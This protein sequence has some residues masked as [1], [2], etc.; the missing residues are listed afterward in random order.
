MPKDYRWEQ[1]KHPGSPN[2]PSRR[3]LSIIIAFIIVGSIVG[4]VLFFKDILFPFI[5]AGI[6]AYVLEPFVKRLA[7]V[8]IPRVLGTFI[9][10]FTVI[11][12]IVGFCYYLV[13]KLSYE[14][15]R[16]FDKLQVMLVEAPETYSRIE[17]RVQEWLGTDAQP[18]QDPTAAIDEAMVAEKGASSWGLGP[19]LHVSRGNSGIQV[20][21]L[22]SIPLT[23]S[24]R[25]LVH[26]E[27]LHLAE[28]VMPDM[29]SRTPEET[30]AL[31]ETS[32]LVIEEIDIGSYGVRFMPATFEVDEDARGQ[33]SIT[34]REEPRSVDRFA[35]MKVEFVQTIIG[36]VESMATGFMGGFLDVIRS[37]LQGFLGA[38]IGLLLVFMVTA[39]MLIGMEDTRAFF[40]G[41]VPAKY[42]DDYEELV[43]ELDEG[44]GGVV[45]GQLAICFINGIL[46]G[47]GFAYFIPEYAIAMAILA[48]TLS[49]IPIF[50][51]IISS[52][53]VVLIGLTTSVMTGVAVLLWILGIHFV[54]ANLLNPKIIGV[55]AR[56]NPVIVIFALIAGEHAF[57][58]PGALLA[59][60]FASIFISVV[61][62][63][64]RR[65]QPHLW[66][67]V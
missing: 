25:D 52:I 15:Q 21:V 27:S 2:P 30:N 41:L 17:D 5:V 60:P 36:G 1:E 12:F 28:L 46:S 3:R 4:M 8:G 18:K 31:R 66:S 23:A 42:K 65:I 40:D 6:L 32:H 20:P 7:K 22:E 29:V 26:N 44:L 11:G 33:V 56:I 48:G 43:Q 63:T 35:N 51:T 38:L 54:E 62:F 47:I 9:V 64:Y 37:L 24:E 45:R 67:A 13:P 19:N 58:I 34:P 10:M 50:G 16:G 49:I 53:P 14:A 39:F 55:A 59:V 57:G 61:K